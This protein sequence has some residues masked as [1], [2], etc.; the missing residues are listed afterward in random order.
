MSNRNNKLAFIQ[1][2]R[3]DTRVPIENAIETLSGFIKEG[4]L[5]HIG[6]S[7]CSAATLRK[8]SAVTVPLLRY[9]LNHANHNVLEVHHIAVVEIEIS[10]WS[11]EEET[12]KGTS[13]MQVATH[14]SENRISVISTAK[15]LGTVV[16]GYSYVMHCFKFIDNCYC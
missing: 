15:E 7:E 1:C 2:A 6:M 4:K 5:D 9:V 8:A 12:K 10:P 16:L 3:V 14:I 13:Y 11:Y